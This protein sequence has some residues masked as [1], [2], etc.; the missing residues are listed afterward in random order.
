M[1]P[2]NSHLLIQG[3]YRDHLDCEEHEDALSIAQQGSIERPWTP[4]YS[5]TIQGLAEAEASTATE[6]IEEIGH[7]SFLLDINTESDS[8]NP[9]IEKVANSVDDL[10]GA[11]EQVSS[12]VCT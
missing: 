2:C 9:Q 10:V 5:V 3:D 11:D 6:D 8:S 12:R 4:S 1:E 7:G